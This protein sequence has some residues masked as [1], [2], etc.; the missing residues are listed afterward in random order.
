MQLQAVAQIIE[1][2]A[3]GQL[4]VQQADGVAPRTEGARLILCPGLSRYFGDF[5]LGNKIANLAQ[6]VE[7]A[8]RWFDCFLFHACRVAGLNRQTNIFLDF[9]WDGCG[10]FLR[11]VAALCLLIANI[12]CDYC[13]RGKHACIAT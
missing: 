12:K 4:G 5:M 2:D 13:C 10:I 9:L 11:F 6:D 8:P 1:S 3:V 7:L